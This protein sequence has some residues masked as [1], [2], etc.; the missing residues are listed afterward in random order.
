MILIQPP[1]P[2]MYH[3]IN[4]QQNDVTRFFHHILAKSLSINFNCMY[5]GISMEIMVDIDQN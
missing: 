3:A 4:C 5:G 2:F 1:L